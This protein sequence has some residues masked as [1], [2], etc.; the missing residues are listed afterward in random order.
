MSRRRLDLTGMQFGSLSVIGPAGS[1]G[2]HSLWVVRCKCGL[3]SVKV[4]K[5]LTKSAHDNKLPQGCSHACPELVNYMS[6]MKTTHGMSHHPAF[7]V[8]RSMLARCS[9]PRHRAY[10]NYGGR[11]ITVCNRWRNS[12]EPFWEDMAPGYAPGLTLDRIDNGG[13][14]CKENCRWASYRIQANN[15]RGNRF[16][17]TPWGLVT[18]SEAARRSGIKKS[19]LYYRLSHN[20]S[21]VNLF[22][23]PDSY[24]KASL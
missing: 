10:K 20:F 15:R 4:G 21:E 3:E 23:T 17:H 16:I 8:W 22:M 24:E 1:D 18:A 6:G 13:G 19:T 14:Y 7:A 5:D 2:L 9:N 12:F 11:G